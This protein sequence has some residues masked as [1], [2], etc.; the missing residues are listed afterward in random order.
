MVS[1]VTVLAAEQPAAVAVSD[2]LRCPAVSSTADGTAVTDLMRR[3][4]ESGI[5]VVLS[6]A[7]PAPQRQVTHPPALVSASRAG[8][9]MHGIHEIFCGTPDQTNVCTDMALTCA[10]IVVQ[11]PMIMP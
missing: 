8:S 9:Q 5:P 4:I 3:L 2:A 11:H 10:R 7:C 1:I 6:A